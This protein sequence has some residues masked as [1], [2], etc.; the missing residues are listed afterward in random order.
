MSRRR[1][2]E[3]CFRARNLSVNTRRTC[4]NDCVTLYVPLFTLECDV[5][6]TSVGVAL[7]AAESGILK[8][9]WSAGAPNKSGDSHSLKLG[10]MQKT[11]YNHV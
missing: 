5:I 2:E 3:N 11:N 1:Y 8:R 10:P 7:N 6:L 4:L 9:D